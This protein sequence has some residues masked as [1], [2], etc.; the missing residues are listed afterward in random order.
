MFWWVIGRTSCVSLHY[1]IM[2]YVF[3]LVQASKQTVLSIIH[4]EHGSEHKSMFML[5]CSAF[6]L[7]ELWFNLTILDSFTFLAIALNH[8]A[9][10]NI[11]IIH[12]CLINQ[13]L[14]YCNLGVGL[15]GKLSLFKYITEWLMYGMIRGRCFFFIHSD[16]LL[17]F[18]M[19]W[20]SKSKQDVYV[21]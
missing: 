7:R 16:L 20:Y 10:Q 14:H 1:Q 17:Y 9:K 4:S 19:D 21:N 2:R 11:Y 15:F 12:Y 6:R 8:F 5:H 18:L 3:D 13:L